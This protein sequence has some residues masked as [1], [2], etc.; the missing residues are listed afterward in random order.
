MNNQ[1]DDYSFYIDEEWHLWQEKKD[2]TEKKRLT[3]EK[4]LCFTYHNG[5]VFYALHDS[6]Y[7]NAGVYGIDLET[8]E[9]EILAD[10]LILSPAD[11]QVIDNCLF[12]F[13]ATGRCVKMDLNSGCQ[14]VFFNESS[15]EYTHCSFENYQ[16]GWIY[17]Y[18]LRVEKTILDSVLDFFLRLFGRYQVKYHHRYYRVDLDGKVEYLRT[19][20][21][22]SFT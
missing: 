19:E 9:S 15:P 5:C 22:R 1:Y 21:G 8:G 11:I 17:F 16:D 14:S 10:A 12:M 2:G 13:C 18:T 3:D 6:L 20:T 7:G 4:A